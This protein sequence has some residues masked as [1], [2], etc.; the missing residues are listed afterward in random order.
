MQTRIKGTREVWLFTALITAIAVLIPLVIVGVTLGL[1]PE[2]YGVKYILPWLAIAGLIPLFITPPIAYVVLNMLRVQADM[3]RRVDA[4]IMFDMMT[5][6]FNRNH[7]LDSVRASKTNGPI[8]I[9]DADHFKS[10]NDSHG[11]A[12]G[13][14]A[15]RVLANAIKQAVGEDGLV[16][17]LGGEEFGVFMPGKT[18]AEGFV[19]AD[20]ICAAIR[21]LHP[22]IGGRQVKLSVSIGASFHRTTKVIGHSLK[23][24]DDL[25]YR[26]KA[27]GRDR[28]V[29]DDSGATQRISA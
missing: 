18:Q 3:I 28:A 22:L 5:G 4:R 1:S 17:R 10:I 23:L 2:A 29:Y 8:M 21:A 11:H 24:A 15:L 9:V 19:K 14:E 20:S 27:E 13:D 25:L 12:V 6:L 16:G 26:A 7:F